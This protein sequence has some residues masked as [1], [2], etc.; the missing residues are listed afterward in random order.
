MHLERWA[1]DLE[2]VYLCDQQNI[3]IVVS[4]SYYKKK[5]GGGAVVVVVVVVVV[6]GGGCV[7][8]EG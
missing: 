7:D 3:P 5:K 4:S 6:V 1:F 8:R 2:L